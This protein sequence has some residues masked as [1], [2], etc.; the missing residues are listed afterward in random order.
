MRYAMRIAE[1]LE[2]QIFERKS[3]WI[4][5]QHV[6]FSVLKIQHHN[7]IESYDSLVDHEG[8][9]SAGQW[10]SHLLLSDLI[11]SNEFT[12]VLYTNFSTTPEIRQENP[13]NLSISVSGGKENN[14]DSPS[15]GERTGKSSK[16][17]S[18]AQVAEL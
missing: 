14:N 11:E 17:K 15:N 16:C 2:H 7:A 9:E 3:R 1:F 5:L 10:S 4:N 8:A 13:L 18:A 6:C 12:K